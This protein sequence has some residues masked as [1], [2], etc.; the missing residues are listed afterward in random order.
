MLSKAQDCRNEELVEEIF[1]SVSEFARLVE[2][3]GNDFRYGVWRVQ[4]DP[5]KDIHFF[6][7]EI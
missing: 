2:S 3:N 6:N 5:R 1:G 4:Y 7:V